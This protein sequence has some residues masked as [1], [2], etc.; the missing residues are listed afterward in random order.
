VGVDRDGVV[1]GL[2]P[3]EPSAKN[4]HLCPPPEY[5]GRRK[6]R[7]QGGVAIGVGMMDG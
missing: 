7:E 4:P 1:R 6:K 2:G 5:M 3:P